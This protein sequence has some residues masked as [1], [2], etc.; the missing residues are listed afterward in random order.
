MR[1]DEL[2]AKLTE[3]VDKTNSVLSKAIDS[4]EKHARRNENMMKLFCGTLVAVIMILGITYAV[5]DW[6][7]TDKMYDYEFANTCTNYNENIN[8]NE[9]DY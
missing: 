6:H 2:I 1:E 4:N 5:T 3:M 9:G 7:K 8:R